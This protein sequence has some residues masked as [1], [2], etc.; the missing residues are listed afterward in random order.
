MMF[1]AM[2]R[3]PP[4]CL[5]PR[6]WGLL[7]RPFLEEPTPFLC[8]MALPD[9]HVGDPNIRELGP[10]PGLA[11]N[12]LAAL[13]SEDVDLLTL[14]VPNDLGGH[15]GAFDHRGTGRNGVA[16]RGQEHLIERDSRARFGLHAG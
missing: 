14:G 9:L 10:V 3:S 13:E 4:K 5:T 8:A 16:V 2:T 11:P 1:P 12:V 7:V 15:A 6:Y